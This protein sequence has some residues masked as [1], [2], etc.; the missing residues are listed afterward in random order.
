VGVDTHGAVVEIPSSEWAYLR[1][2]E[3]RE[4]DILGYDA[5][6]Q[7]EP[8]TAVTLGRSDVL[9]LWSMTGVVVDKG[10]RPAE[11]DWAAI[12]EIAVQQI[13]KFGKPHKD[14]KRLPTKAQLIELILGEYAIRFDRQP[15]ISSMKAHL[16]GWLAEMK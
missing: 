2:R 10:G 13:K 11:Y 12:K 4:R 16:K 6:S 8:F 5:V 9:R 14:N 7:P 3:E 15:P 1:L